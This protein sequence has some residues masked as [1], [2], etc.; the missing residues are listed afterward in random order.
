MAD[1]AKLTRPTWILAAVGAALV[2][3]GSLV[4]HA[5]QTAGGVTVREVRFTGAKGAAMSGLLYTP[6]GV[7]AQNPAPGVLAVHGY[8]NTRETQ[9]PFAIE[10]ARRGYVVLAMDQRGH[11]YS[12]GAA[13]SE[14]F[15]GPDGLAFLRSL[16]I[17]DKDQVGMEGHS[18]GGW[19]AL[20]AAKAIPDGYRALVL[21]G[22]STG[23]P[24]AA[25][26]T[27]T[28]PRNLAVVF[29]R[30]D[31]FSG[32]MWGV[33]RAA[34]VGR[35]DKLKA[36][37]GTADEVKPGVIYG[38]I[39]TGTARVLHI[40]AT[41]HPGDHLSTEAVGRATDWFARTLV[42]GTPRPASDQIWW[43]KELATLVALA[44]F[45]TLVLGLFAALISMPAFASL[46]AAPVFARQT[47]GGPGWWA[48]L[49]LGAL[50]PAVSLL[51]LPLV[52]VN[53]LP[54]SAAFPQGVT[55]QLV[56]WAVANAVVAL[57]LGL[58]LR[59]RTPASGAPLMPA[60][61]LAALV[62]VIAYAVVALV[63]RLLVVD[64]RFW[65]VALKPLSAAQAGAAL[66]YLLPLTLFVAVAYRGLAGLMAERQGAAAQYLTGMAA[67]AGGFLVVIGAAYALLFMT[68]GLPAWLPALN[69]ILGIQFVPVLA[70]LGALFVFTWRRTGS[71]IPGT[72]IAGPLVTWYMVA[73]TATHFA[74]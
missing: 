61:G 39:A 67:L 14:G 1:A 58:V 68:G 59:N 2:L 50:V 54:L 56:V 57:V 43:W 46:R 35:S 23:A 10:F 13:M 20:A 17:V 5:V 33:P 49:L 60:L 16:P 8:I 64:F 66:A 51:F 47:P 29:S 11:G 69:A 55:N 9:S 25:D 15:G 53:W 48:L 40:P 12:G 6:K 30:Y 28:W 72:L 71:W 7:S 38:D 62:L 22:S 73:G 34:E 42:G 27:P 45:V 41:T 36:A 65:V 26:A 3:F 44:G 19:T 24:Y 18:M 63:G 70:V 4:A 31:E 52:G 21:E 32:L 37:F 74:G